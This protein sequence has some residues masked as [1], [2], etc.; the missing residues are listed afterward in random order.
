M[1]CPKCGYISFDHLAECRKCHKNIE[2]VSGSLYGTAYS[3]QPPT[4]LN[5]HRAEREED[6]EEMELTEESTFGDDEEYIDDEL[7][8]LVEEED[9]EPEGDIGFS[10]GPQ[11]SPQLS[12]DDE[13]EDD[14][15][16]EIDFSQ[17][18]AA[19][20]SETDSFE[21]EV[22]EAAEEDDLKEFAMKIDMPDALSD[23]SDLAPPAKTSADD[24]LPAEN[25]ADE[26]IAEMSFD[27]LN[28]DLGLDD[29]DKD[30]AG[31][32]VHEEAMLA[33]DEID[34]SEAPAAGSSATKKTTGNADMDLD[35][36]FE[37][38]LGGLSIHKD[39]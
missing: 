23:I 1:R 5:L 11:A 21:E 2:A 14:G 33:L 38:D 19:D 15:E 18:E 36:D 17:F 26:K 13:Q 28:F 24:E 7:A 31:P 39:V 9:E 22:A 35:L 6:F 4:F 30:Q 37:L 29:L 16:I 8:I 20:D 12:A 10:G 27:D 32:D 3:V 25:P 34:F